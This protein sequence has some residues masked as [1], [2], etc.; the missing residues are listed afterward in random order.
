M[1]KFLPIGFGN[2]VLVEQ[3]TTIC[4]PDTAPI[5]RQIKAAEENGNLLDLTYGRKTRS[6]IF[7]TDYVILC[8]LQPET[9]AKRA[10]GVL[11]TEE[12]E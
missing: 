4:D 1:F 5:K 9:L 10:E 11:E 2:V 3:I 12:D 8:H 7:T 6:V